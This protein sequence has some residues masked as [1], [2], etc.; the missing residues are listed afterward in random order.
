MVAFLVVLEISFRFTVYLVFGSEKERSL[1][2]S[3]KELG[4]VHNTS[5]KTRLKTNRCGENVVYLPSRHRLINKY[6]RY[7][8]KKIILFIG[9]SF[10][11]GH[12]VS[13]GEAYYDIFERLEKDNYSVYAAGIG[14]YGSLQ[15]YMA[16]TLL[17]DEIK[18]DI[19]VWQL[20]SNDISNNVYELDNSSF[21][22]NQ[23]PRPYLNIE[24]NQIEIKNPGFFLFDW[25][26]G[27]KYI[28]GRVLVLDRKYELG[29]LKKANSI[30]GLRPKD[31]DK[32]TKQGLN[33]L[34]QLVA[35]A[36]IQY[37]KSK[38]VGFSTDPIFES[39]YKAI[40]MENGGEYLDKFYSC[41]VGAGRTNCNPLD[42]HWN[43][44]GNLVAGKKMSEMIKKIQ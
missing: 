4:W 38:F 1:L 20:C 5:Y 41:F 3:D 25:S 28:F 40:F 7:S 24:S 14:G 36:V 13:T 18:P 34:S 29:I 43:H 6:P 30:I 42:A 15:E 31:Q 2:S 26:L 32:Y 19:V 35:T 22:N 39:E 33:V 21:F 27:F 11:H 23:M 16:I 10:T 12:E 37:P 8:G 17:S 44:L 9:D